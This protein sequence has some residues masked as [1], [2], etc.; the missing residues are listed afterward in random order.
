MD[1]DL[2]LFDLSSPKAAESWGSIDDRVMGR[3]G[4]DP[5]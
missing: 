5:S 3:M 1:K 4:S 2:K